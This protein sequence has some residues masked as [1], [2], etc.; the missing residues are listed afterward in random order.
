MYAVG[1]V[2]DLGALWIVAVGIGG[3]VVLGAGCDGDEPP[4]PRDGPYAVVDVEWETDDDAQS[5]APRGEQYRDWFQ[6]AVDHSQR[7]LSN[8]GDGFAVTAKIHH[9]ASVEERDGS[10]Q[11]VVEIQTDLVEEVRPDDEPSLTLTTEAEFLH[12]LSKKHPTD[13][14]LM[15]VSRTLGKEATEKIVEQL[16]HQARVRQGEAWELVRWTRAST[17]ED[18][19]R[20]L[21]M[22]EMVRRQVEGAGPALRT[23]ADDESTAVAAGAAEALYDLESDGAAHAVMDVAQRMSRDEHY[24]EYLRLLSVVGKLDA[25]WVSI[26]LETVAQAHSD[27]RVRQKARSISAERPSIE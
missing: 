12:P 9:T 24:D 19:K 23:A 17:M 16:R 4:G 2:G 7:G 6:G 13:Q 8:G 18:E 11:L 22:R 5:W 26:Y 3:L 21:A 10:P 27:Y 25:P 14:V 15:Q 20:L 1:G